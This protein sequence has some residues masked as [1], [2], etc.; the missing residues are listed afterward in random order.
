[1]QQPDFQQVPIGQLR[2]SKT[3]SQIERR[4]H[5][6]KGAITE[7]AIS[8]GEVG[9]LQPLVVRPIKRSAGLN[10]LPTDPTHE[11]VAGER[12]YLA[13]KEAGLKALPVNVRELTD[14]QVS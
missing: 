12:R 3:T 8:I 5:L 9:L 11:V 13:A 1:M 10:Y 6:D 2:L 7:L 4:A 14:E